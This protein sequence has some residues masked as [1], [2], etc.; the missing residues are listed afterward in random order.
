MKLANQYM[1][2]L[3]NFNHIKSSS[4]TIS[5]VVEEDAII[6]LKG[7]KLTGCMFNQLIFV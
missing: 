1:A 3:F 4:P 2:I 7:L 6:S 5:L